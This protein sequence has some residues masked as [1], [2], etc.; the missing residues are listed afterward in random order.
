M[1]NI[2]KNSLKIVKRL[3]PLNVLKCISFKIVRHFN[4]YNE[5]SFHYRKPNSVLYGNNISQ[6]VKCPFIQVDQQSG[7]ETR[8]TYWTGFKS[9]T[10]STFYSPSMVRKY[11]CIELI[12]TCNRPIKPETY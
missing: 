11:P 6:I 10:A 4:N 8:V 2:D 3:K 5:D 7:V 9:F 12:Y 1:Y